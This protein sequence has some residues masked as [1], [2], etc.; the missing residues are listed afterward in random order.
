MKIELKEIP[1]REVVAGYVD[2]AEGGVRGY[3]DR[4]VGYN[5]RMEW[6]TTKKS[7]SRRGGGK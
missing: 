1:V 6:Q 5:V 2:S 3:G 4:K 7:G